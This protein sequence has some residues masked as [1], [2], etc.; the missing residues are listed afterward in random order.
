MGG[1]GRGR[2]MAKQATERSASGEHATPIDRERV[3]RSMRKNAPHKQTQMSERM[4]CEAV[5]TVD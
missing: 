3:T 5:R 1:G 2:R 4:R